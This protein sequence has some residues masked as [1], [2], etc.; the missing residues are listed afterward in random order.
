[1][2]DMIDKIDVRVWK[3]PTMRSVDKLDLGFFR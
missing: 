1:M 2:L 3:V